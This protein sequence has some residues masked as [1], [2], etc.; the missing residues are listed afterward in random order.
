MSAKMGMGI[1]EKKSKKAS[2]KMSKKS[3]KTKQNKILQ[4]N[5]IK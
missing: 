1:S 4:I 3:A 2:A 5:Q